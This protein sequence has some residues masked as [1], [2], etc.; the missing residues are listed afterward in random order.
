MNAPC[1]QHQVIDPVG[2]VCPSPPDHPPERQPAEMDPLQAERGRAAR[3]VPAQV[4][5]L[6]RALPVPGMR[7]ATPPTPRWSS[8]PPKPLGER[9]L[10]VPHPAASCRATGPTA[11]PAA[12]S[13]LRS[14]VEC[15]SQPQPR[16]V[17][18]SAPAANLV[19]DRK[20][21]KSFSPAVGRDQPGSPSRTAACALAAC[22]YTGSGSPGSNF[23]GDHPE[24][25]I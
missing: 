13:G 20:L 1:Q 3:H 9:Q 5:D 4:R 25:S 18:P 21:P 8:A 22:S 6:V 24:R 12:P 2:G 15:P 17:P 19:L 14:R 10:P 16:R 7:P 11:A 23:F